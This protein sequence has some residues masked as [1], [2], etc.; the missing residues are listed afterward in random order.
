MKK[1]LSLLCLAAA[2]LF[3]AGA[4]EF[5]QLNPFSCTSIMVGKKASTDGAV[6]TSHTCDSHY[7]T[8]VEIVESIEY[9]NDT[10]VNVFKNRLHTES[11]KGSYRMSLL[12]LH[13]REAAGYGRDHYYRTPRP[14]Q[15]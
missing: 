4:T 7:R 13:E 15:P 1:I 6:I 9:A 11:A 8:W 12:S 2:A 3:S 10:T 14:R 5:P